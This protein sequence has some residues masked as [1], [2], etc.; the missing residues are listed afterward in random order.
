MATDLERLPICAAVSRL[1]HLALTAPQG[2]TLF[3]DIHSHV[4]S[5]NIELQACTDFTD[6][7]KP[8]C[9]PVCKRIYLDKPDAVTHLQ[10]AILAIKLQ[11]ERPAKEVYAEF[12]ASNKQEA[13]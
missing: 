1:T 9:R 7:T 8:R 3:V 5:A 6:R 10:S 4:M 12:I 11:Y 13:A 2:Y